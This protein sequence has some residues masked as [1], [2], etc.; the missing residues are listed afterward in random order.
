MDFDHIEQLTSVEF[1]E[2]VKLRLLEGDTIEKI[3]TIDN[4]PSSLNI[5][6]LICTPSKMFPG[7]VIKRIVEWRFWKE[8][9]K[10]EIEYAVSI[11]KIE[12]LLNWV[13]I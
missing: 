6:L 8:D 1:I 3:D 10:F 5:R 12:E 9:Q 7:E 4:L 13:K 11:T 2:A